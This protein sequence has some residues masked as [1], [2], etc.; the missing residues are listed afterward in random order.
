MELDKIKVDEL[1]LS[2]IV[3]D[4]EH[5]HLRIPRFQRDFVWERS[6]VVKLLD[7]IYKEYPIGSFFIWEA[8]KKYNLYYRNVAEL[9]LPKPDSYSSIRYILDGQQRATSLY[10][11]IKGLQINGTEYSQIHFDFDKEKFVIRYRQHENSASLR[12][13]LDENKHLKIYNKLSD[14]R[15]RVLERCR[16]IFSTYPLSVI[17][18]REKELAEASDIFERIN[19]GGKRLALFDLVVAGT[20]GTD[21]DLKV[22]YHE[23]RDEIDKENGF[24]KITPEVVTHA[25]SLMV[26]GYCRKSYQLQLTKEELKDNWE[27]I[28]NSIKLAV[29]YLYNNLGVKIFDFVPYPAM[30]SLLAY[31]YYQTPGRSLNKQMAEKVHEWFWKAALSERYGGLRETR[32]EEDR[33]LIFDKLIKTGDA[34]INYPIALD[35]ERIAKSKVSTKSALRNA[36]F[37]LFALRQ[38]KHFKTNAAIPLDSKICSEFNSPEKHHIFPKQFLR[39]NNI[40]GEYLMAN[41]CFIPAELNKEILNKKPSDYFEKFEKENPDFEAALKIQLITYNNAIKENDYESFIQ[42]RSQDIFKEFERL[43]GSKILQIAGQN[44][45]RAI[46]EIEMQLRSLIDAVMLKEYRGSYW[47]DVIPT[48]IQ[49]RVHR[50]IDGHIK[51]NPS[52]R[53]DIFTTSDKLDFC[54]IM[55][56]SNI[57]LK[58]WELFEDIFG[59][60]FEI[61][62]RFVALKDFRNAIKH[63]REVNSVLQKDGEA[64][65]EWFSQLLT[66][67][68]RKIDKGEDIEKIKDS[69]TPPESDE[70]IIDRVNSEFAKKAVKL[71]PEWIDKEYSDG[72]LYIRKSSGSSHSILRGDSLVFYYHFALNWVFGSLRYTTVEELELLRNKLSKPSSIYEY[73]DRY[74]QVRFHMIN[75]EDLKLVQDIIKQRSKMD[76]VITDEDLSAKNRHV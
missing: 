16:R 5:G 73:K 46:D 49:D 30:I 59:S 41:F 32:M 33:R 52:E 68:V 67:V 27:E 23:L 15:K 26:K 72:E 6:K 48:D 70:Q 47:N 65:L 20:W 40:S 43:I 36:F 10:A 21:F 25:A 31:L 66:K 19:Q 24:G 42:E 13:I 62:K 71:I 2:D 61:E 28:T 60:K 76:F 11:V 55:D 56:Y 22:L 37:C 35:V 38:P 12:D 45:N 34:N 14:Q 75:E 18:V 69:V 39:R 17:T 58:N 51:K 64:A 57:I 50:K 4:I 54:D 53:D 9:N 3:H 74:S 8:D 7:S 1:K 44:A 29:D 63:N